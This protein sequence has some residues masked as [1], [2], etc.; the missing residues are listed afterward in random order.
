[1]TLLWYALA[2]SLPLFAGAALG[3]WWRPPR[4]VLASAMSFAAGAL[5]ASVAFELVSDSVGRAGPVTAALAFAGGTVMFVAV[6]W[7]LERRMRG[8]ATPFVVLAAA[9]LD[10]IPENLALGVTLAHGRSVALLAAIALANLP[11]GVAGAA[12]MREKGHSRRRVLWI[13]AGTTALLIGAVGVGNVLFRSDTGDAPAL[14]LAFA[15]GAVLAAVVDTFAPQAF[16]R[17]GPTVALAT[18][19]GFFGVFLLSS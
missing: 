12:L 4:R 9:A 13:W 15:G 7:V 2:A 11:E 17:G 14:P 10:S 5:L 16:E 6:D 18:A 8:G 3:T 19:A 1:M